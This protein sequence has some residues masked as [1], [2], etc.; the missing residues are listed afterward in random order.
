MALIILPYYLV[1]AGPLLEH[2]YFRWEDSCLS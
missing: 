2:V 1:I